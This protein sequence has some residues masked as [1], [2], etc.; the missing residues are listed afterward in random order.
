[1]IGINTRVDQYVVGWLNVPLLG[2]TKIQ[3]D[4]FGFRA[5]S[6]ALV[7]ERKQN[8]GL[9]HVAQRGIFNHYAGGLAA[10]SAINA[11]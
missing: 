1:M 9:R 7:S 8:L 10:G 4:F 6:L 5:I 3:L 2:Q 11:G